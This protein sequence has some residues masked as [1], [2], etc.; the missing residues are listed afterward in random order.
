MREL[1]LHPGGEDTD[2]VLAMWLS[3][4]AAREGGRSDMSVA[5][6]NR[7]LRSLDDLYQPSRWRCMGDGRDPWDRPS[8][9]R[10]DG[11]EW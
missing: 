2:C 10:M 4:L 6:A 9:L 7:A 11:E 1:R 8:W 3:E 5:A